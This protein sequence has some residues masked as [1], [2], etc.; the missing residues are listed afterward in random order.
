[1]HGVLAN[2]AGK[3][4]PDGTRRC[5]R[6][7]SSPDERAKIFNC[8]VLFKDRCNNRTRAH[9]RYKFLIKRTLAVHSIKLS[10]FFCRKFCEL[11]RNNAEARLVDFV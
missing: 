7:I 5:L 6:G 3:H 2:A 10:R 8:I 4:S 1:M 11:H 9:E